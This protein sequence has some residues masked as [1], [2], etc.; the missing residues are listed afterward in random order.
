MANGRLGKDTK[1]QT[2]PIMKMITKH[3]SYLILL[4]GLTVFSGCDIVNPQDEDTEAIELILADPFVWRLQVRTHTSD[5]N[6]AGTDA[7]VFVRFNEEREFWLNLGGSDRDRN[8]TNIYDV[9]LLYEEGHEQVEEGHAQVGEPIIQRM[10]DIHSISFGTRGGDRWIFDRVEILINN[11]FDRNA[12][13]EQTAPYVVA[14]IS[15]EV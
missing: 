11:P 1:I 6:R 15:G 7:Q 2:Y 5:V 4:L 9:L 12:T 10:S 8:E 3:F 13:R 14:D